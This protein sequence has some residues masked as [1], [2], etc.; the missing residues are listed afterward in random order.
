[1]QLYFVLGQIHGDPEPHSLNAIAIESEKDAGVKGRGELK[2]E[3]EAKLLEFTSLR[4]QLMKPCIFSL[5][6]LDQLLYYKLF[7]L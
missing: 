1:M 3:S 4:L 7:S 6:P 5:L 2:A